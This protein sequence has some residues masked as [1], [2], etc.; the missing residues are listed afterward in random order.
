MRSDVLEHSAIEVFEQARDRG[1]ERDHAEDAG[2]DLAVDGTVEPE[3]AA[4][5]PDRDARHPI[6]DLACST[7]S[8]LRRT[9]S[10]SRKISP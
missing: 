8:H 3:P 7:S 5:G 10:D 4:T 9:G 1:R 2:E 6:A